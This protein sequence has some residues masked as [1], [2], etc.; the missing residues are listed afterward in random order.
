MVIQG[1]LRQHLAR[2]ELARRRQRQQE[3]QVQM[4]KLQRE[5]SGEGEEGDAGAVQLGG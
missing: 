3:Y 4:E 2:R 1:A 5:V